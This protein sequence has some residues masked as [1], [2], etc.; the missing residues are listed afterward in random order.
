M[1][2]IASNLFNHAM[3]LSLTFF[4][5]GCGRGGPRTYPVHGKLEITG[6]NVAQLAGSHIEAAIANE[7]TKR[8]SGVIRDD[9]SFTLETPHAGATI[10]GARAGAY[11]VRIVLSDDDA[12]ARRR[13]AQAI[14]ARYLDFQTSG[15]TFEVPA[16][17]PINLYAT[18]R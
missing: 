7:L 13:A 2:P 14:A 9:G 17:G 3:I 18:A 10:G 8:A 6:G 4:A 12:P 15:L 16:S 11:L 5:L 1:R